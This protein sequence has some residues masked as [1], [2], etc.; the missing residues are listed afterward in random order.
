MA[1]RDREFH[2][3]RAALLA[4][5]EFVGSVRVSK[6]FRASEIDKALAELGIEE[7]GELEAACKPGDLIQELRAQ[8]SSEQLEAAARLAKTMVRPVKRQPLREW[9]R[10]LRHRLRRSSVPAP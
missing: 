7:K 10:R 8:L 5:Q 4:G 9:L 6:D 3:A 1:R 2:V